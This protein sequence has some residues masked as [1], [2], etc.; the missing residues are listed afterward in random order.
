MNSSISRNLVTT[1]LGLVMVIAPLALWIAWSEKIFWGVLLSFGLAFCF[2]VL[3]D[4]TEAG[5]D[6]R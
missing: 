5:K 6:E 2:L 4:K 3:I 1:I